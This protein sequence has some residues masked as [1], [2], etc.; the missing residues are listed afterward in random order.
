MS[1]PAH[2]AVKHELLVRY[3]DAWTPAALHR[4]KR[5]VYVSWADVAGAETALRVFAEF[6]DIVEDRPVTM[7][8]PAT[9]RL[10][11]LT[12]VP[13]VIV[14]VVDGALTVPAKGASVLG[15]FDGCG[16]SSA[17]STVVAVA[18]AEVMVAGPPVDA[19]LACRVE[20]VD[21]S[22]QAELMT[23]ATASEKSLERFK[24]ELW[25]L[26]EYAGIQFRDP[27]DVQGELSD[28]SAV[29]HL[30]PLRRMMLRHLTGAGNGLSVADLR[31]WTLHETVFRASDATRAVQALLSANTVTRDPPNGRISADTVIRARTRSG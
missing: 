6:A 18:G 23:F 15:W 21:A 30:G 17:V 9:I 4:H 19:C 7:L 28:I 16:D 14:S 27:A 5:A 31:T 2:T 26:D 25:A 24:E 20:L 12:P 8:V 3:L 10:D 29:A 22:G 13:G 11:Q 1:G